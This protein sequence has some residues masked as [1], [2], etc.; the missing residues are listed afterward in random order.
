MLSM[1]IAMAPSALGSL[2]M[3]LLVASLYLGSL[4][5]K[6]FHGYMVEAHAAQSM[7]L[8]E[9]YDS[10]DS[11]VWQLATALACNSWIGPALSRA[12]YIAEAAV[13]AAAAIVGFSPPDR[14]PQVVQV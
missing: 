2:A 3:I 1:A 14:V 11:P 13:G 12:A 8:S 7:I 6:D 4:I 10:R 5:H 9:F